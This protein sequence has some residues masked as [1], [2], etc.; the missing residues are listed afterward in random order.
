MAKKNRGISAFGGVI[1]TKLAT[2]TN[3]LTYSLNTWLITYAR[4][5][6]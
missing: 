1:S 5:V 3:L 6:E 2:A 4:L